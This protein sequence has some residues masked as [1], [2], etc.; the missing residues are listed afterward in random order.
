[1]GGDKSKGGGAGRVPGVGWVN[2]HHKENGTEK[3][4]LF[5]MVKMGKSAT[6]VGDGL[7]LQ[8]LFDSV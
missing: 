2:G 8:N 1:M 3:M 5:E 7:V 6:Q 4:T